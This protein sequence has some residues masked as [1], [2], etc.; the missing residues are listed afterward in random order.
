MKKKNF[1]KKYVFLGTSLSILLLAPLVQAQPFDVNSLV[2]VIQSL[3]SG[4]FNLNSLTGIV[5]DISS[6]TS[7]T[8]TTDLG[9]F[10]SDLGDLSSADFSLGSLDSY[11]SGSFSEL[12]GVTDGF[13]TT[14]GLDG[15]RG[16]SNSLGISQSTINKITN[17]SKFAKGLFGAASSGNFSSILENGL[18]ILGALGLLNPQSAA[19]ITGAGVAGSSLGGSDAAAAS[20]Y[21]EAKQAKTPFEVYVYSKKSQGMVR[22][23]NNNISQIVLGEEGQAFSANQAKESSLALEAGREGASK[24]GKYVLNGVE[25]NQTSEKAVSA[26]TKAAETCLAAKQTLDCQKQQAIIQAAMAGQLSI[27][28]GGQ[29]LQTASLFNLG[30]QLNAQ[31][32]IEKING[33]RLQKLEIQG[34]ATVNQLSEVSGVLEKTYQHKAEA[35]L[36]AMSYVKQS[37]AVML[38]PGLYSDASNTSK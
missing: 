14:S 8:T 3:A 7:S 15:L 9:T 20:V 11:D 27:L 35:E 2:G 37:T 16:G 1:R 24:I 33:D 34:A 23:A 17:S 25:L 21:E 22:L 18:G 31:S 29:T 26:A 10:S 4:N 28:S 12:D 13:D 36:S 19:S 6:I 5:S 32:A 30:N 38:L